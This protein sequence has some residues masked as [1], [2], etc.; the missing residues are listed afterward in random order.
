MTFKFLSTNQRDGLV[1]VVIKWNVS[2]PIAM[3]Y[4]IIIYI[5]ELFMANT[6]IKDN[7]TGRDKSTRLSRKRRLGNANNL[8]IEN[9]IDRTRR[10]IKINR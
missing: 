10:Y 5:A 1:L 2:F 8:W 6:I 7:G 3:N 4:R 9:K